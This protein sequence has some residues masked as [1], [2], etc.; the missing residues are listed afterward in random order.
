MKKRVIL[1]S[2]VLWCAA[3]MMV[4]SPAFAGASQQ[5]A[6][7]KALIG[8]L[9]GMVQD[10]VATLENTNPAFAAHTLFAL[11]CLDNAVKTG[12]AEDVPE[13]L[14]MYAQSIIYQDNQTIP[15]ECYTKLISPTLGVVTLLKDIATA[16]TTQCVAVLAVKDITRITRGIMELNLCILESADNPDQAAIDELNSQITAIKLLYIVLNLTKVGLG[17]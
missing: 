7:S 9:V 4:C 11:D 5:D 17:C 14:D 12:N 1:L 15:Q 10:S 3:A 16:E 8:G 2:A 13:V 6:D